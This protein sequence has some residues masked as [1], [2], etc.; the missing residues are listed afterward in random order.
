M[1]SNSLKN[2]GKPGMA[3]VGRL[4]L[5][6]QTRV[7]DLCDGRYNNLGELARAMGVL[8][9]QVY[10]VRQGKRRIN[11]KFVIGALKAFPNRRLDELFYLESVSVAGGMEEP[12]I[13]S[14]H[15]HIIEQYKKPNT[16]EHKQV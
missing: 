7:F 16:F 4:D 3:R 8:L 5:K 2:I 14:R 11:E 13:V 15:K 12:S 6:L 9:S 10:R 1:S